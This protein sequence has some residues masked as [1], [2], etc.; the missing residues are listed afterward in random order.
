MELDRGLEFRDLLLGDDQRREELEALLTAR[1]ADPSLAALVG[2]ISG[3]LE[4]LEQ[5]E[6]IVDAHLPLG[7]PDEAVSYALAPASGFSAASVLQ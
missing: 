7:T 4:Q 5:L 2:A 1:V 6:R 3:P